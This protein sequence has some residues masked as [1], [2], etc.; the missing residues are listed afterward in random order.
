MLQGKTNCRIFISINETVESL[1]KECLG[2][3]ED[4]L[5]FPSPKTGGKGT[6]VKKG[7]IGAYTLAKIPKISVRD[8]RRTAAI[9]LLDRGANHI[10]IAALLGHS[11]FYA[12]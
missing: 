12:W 10:T 1:L 6:S 5:V 4:E 2:R 11:N 9:R 3:H 7:V 8:L